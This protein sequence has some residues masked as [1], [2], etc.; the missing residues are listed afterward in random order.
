MPFKADPLNEYAKIIGIIGPETDNNTK[1]NIS[2]GVSI[3]KVTNTTIAH[4]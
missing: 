1:D 4:I 3:L 2:I